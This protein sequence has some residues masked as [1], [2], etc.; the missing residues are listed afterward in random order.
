MK[1]ISLITSGITTCSDCIRLTAEDRQWI[2]NYYLKVCPD[3]FDQN[4]PFATKS[5]GHGST[6]I[7]E[8]GTRMKKKGL[9]FDVPRVRELNLSYEDLVFRLAGAEEML[10]VSKSNYD[11]LES[12]CNQYEQTL[13]SLVSA[14][15]QDR[16]NVMSSSL[17]LAK[18]IR[19]ELEN[20][21]AKGAKLDNQR[22]ARKAA[23]A[24]HSAPGGSRDKKQSIRDVWMLGR[25]SSRDICAEE[26]YAALGFNTFSAAR[27]ALRNT[28]DPKT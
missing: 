12:I 18:A 13:R 19:E 4:T 24:R 16:A 6:T 20:A 9:L 21:A 2:M 3:L 27:K 23:D 11:W 1:K 15:E 5:S 7:L 17:I 10:E 25:Y 22:R 26:E 28:L 8:D 14:L